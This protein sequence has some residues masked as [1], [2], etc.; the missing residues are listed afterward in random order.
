MSIRL[1][2]GSVLVLDSLCTVPIESCNIVGHAIKQQVPCQIIKYLQYDII[3]VMDLL[4][5]TN[6]VIDSVV[7]SLDLTVG[8]Q[9]HTVFSFSEQC[10]QCCPVKFEVSAG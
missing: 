7:C 5:S 6:P 9:L 3:L 4:K 1:A 2:T 8:A 10:S